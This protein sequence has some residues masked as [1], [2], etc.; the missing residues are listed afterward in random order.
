[1]EDSNAFSL[2][3]LSGDPGGQPILISNFVNGI[4]EEN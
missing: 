2:P 3:A 1:M 4:S